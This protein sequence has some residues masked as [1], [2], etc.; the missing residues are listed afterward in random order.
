MFWIS[1]FYSWGQLHLKLLRW[2]SLPSSVRTTPKL[3][4]LL[5]A[6]NQGS[7]PSSFSTDCSLS[8]RTGGR[9]VLL[10]DLT[11]SKRAFREF[12]TGGLGWKFMSLSSRYLRKT[13]RQ[14]HSVL[15]IIVIK[16]FWWLSVTRSWKT[17]LGSYPITSIQVLFV[18]HSEVRREFYAGCPASLLALGTANQS[19]EGLPEYSWELFCSLFWK[20]GK[21]QWSGLCSFI[22]LTFQKF[23]L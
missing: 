10:Y 3:Q 1:R 13:A 6:A 7:V 4:G 18:R 15:K 11:E 8:L 22:Y 21:E 5:E 16:S 14:K 2:L 19:Q 17:Q 20:E 9:D 12:F 23:F